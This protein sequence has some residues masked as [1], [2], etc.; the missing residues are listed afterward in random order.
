[1]TCYF[2][3]CKYNV[4]TIFTIN[5]REIPSIAHLHLNLLSSIVSSLIGSPLFNKQIQIPLLLFRPL[6]YICSSP[7]C[8]TN[9]YFFYFQKTVL[10][11]F[12]PETQCK[13]FQ[14]FP[15][16]SENLFILKIGRKVKLPRIRS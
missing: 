4:S 2:G 10:Y 15:K 13:A 6:L 9:P 12:R 14:Q 1:M 8:F 11:Y 5:I 16:L 7:I 3:I